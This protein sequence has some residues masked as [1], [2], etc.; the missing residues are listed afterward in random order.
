M[1]RPKPLND[2]LGGTDSFL[3]QIVR[4]HVESSKGTHNAFT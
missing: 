1:S 2:L 4:D 3:K